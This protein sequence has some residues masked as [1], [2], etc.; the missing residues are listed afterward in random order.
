MRGRNR[1]R[2]SDN[3]LKI[4]SPKHGILTLTYG[5]VK[6]LTASIFRARVLLVTKGREAR[7][8]ELDTSLF[9][10]SN[11]FDAG[12]LIPAPILESTVVAEEEVCR[13]TMY[14]NCPP[15]R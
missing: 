1:R 7:N 10:L 8:D 14:E 11:R 9:S 12:R 6:K 15:R 2:I 13:L 5:I 4:N 3:A